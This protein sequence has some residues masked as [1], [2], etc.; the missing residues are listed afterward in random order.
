MLRA[1]VSVLIS[2]GEFA[3]SRH[4]LDRKAR[5]TN[6]SVSFIKVSRYSY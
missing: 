4:L 5:T 1:S 2:T 3:Y 6:E